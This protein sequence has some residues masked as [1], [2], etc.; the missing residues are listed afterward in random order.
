MW[1]GGGG[2]SIFDIFRYVH[3]EPTSMPSLLINRVQPGTKSG[4]VNTVVTAACTTPLHGSRSN[5]R[6]LAM[7]SDRA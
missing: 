3:V 7:Q 6:Q 5:C 4:A 1:G 2:G